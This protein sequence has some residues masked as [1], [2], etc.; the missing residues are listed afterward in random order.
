M[1]RL[2]VIDQDTDSAYRT[3]VSDVTKGSTA[4]NTSNRTVPRVIEA[5]STLLEDCEPMPSRDLE[6]E[7]DQ[8][9]QSVAPP[10]LG[11]ISSA[12]LVP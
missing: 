11:G 6:A 9:V 1:R 3:R 5:L 8:V 10:F 12:T 7:H 2:T 4:T